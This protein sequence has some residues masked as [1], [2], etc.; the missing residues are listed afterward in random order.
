MT[1]CIAV[2]FVYSIRPTN[3]LRYCIKFLVFFRSDS[4]DEIKSNIMKCTELV[5]K[6]I[7]EQA[8]Y[9]RACAENK[10]LN[11]DKHKKDINQEM[12]QSKSSKRKK[13]NDKDNRT[14]GNKVSIIINKVH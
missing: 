12:K 14:N 4:E 3:Q 10:K 11:L 2:F 8:A 1:P 13:C 5:N 6:T 7:I 9:I